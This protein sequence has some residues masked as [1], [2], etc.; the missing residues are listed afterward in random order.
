MFGM[1]NKKTIYVLYHGV[2]W[3]TVKQDVDARESSWK[4]AYLSIPLVG[5]E[6]GKL[7]LAKARGSVKQKIEKD[8]VLVKRMA[9]GLTIKTVVFTN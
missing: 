5:K 8:C 3:V 1:N 4:W 9:I 2:G 6:L 7:V